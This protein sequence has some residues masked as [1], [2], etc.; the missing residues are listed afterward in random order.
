MK[1]QSFIKIYYSPRKRT[2]NH[3]T[4]SNS[5]SRACTR[6]FQLIERHAQPR[7]NRMAKRSRSMITTHSSYNVHRLRKINISCSP[8]NQTPTIHI[9]ISLPHIKN[10]PTPLWLNINPTPLT[11]LPFKPPFANGWIAVLPRSENKTSR[12]IQCERK[13]NLIELW[14]SWPA[15]YS[16]ARGIRGPSCTYV[17]IIGAHKGTKGMFFEESTCSR[18]NGIFVGPIEKFLRGPRRRLDSFGRGG[19][20]EGA[21]GQSA[22][23]LRDVLCRRLRLAELHSTKA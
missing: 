18:T 21:K 10:N 22:I 11:N 15:Q 7:S 14:R 9:F 20:N 8:T 17:C 23:I 5:L 12:P 4:K 6:L 13:G 1:L 3:R 19:N 2:R 16:I